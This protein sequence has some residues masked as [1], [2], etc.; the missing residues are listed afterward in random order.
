MRFH[1]IAVLA[2]AALGLMVGASAAIGGDYEYSRCWKVFA[3]KNRLVWANAC[4]PGDAVVFK[5]R[6]LERRER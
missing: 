3:A 6:D 1:L 2:T 5:L 4:N